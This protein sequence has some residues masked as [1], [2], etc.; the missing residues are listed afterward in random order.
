MLQFCKAYLRH[1]K[2]VATV[3]AVVVL[4]CAVCI[5]QVKV[6][7]SMTDYLPADSPSVQALNDMEE[8]FGAGTVNARLYAEGV[9][10]AQASQLA[11]DLAA[12][13][14]IDEVMW[15]GSVVDIRQP[16]ETIR[17]DT[18]ES[19]VTDDGYLY[20]LAISD[21]LGMQASEQARTTA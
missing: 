16:I 6:N 11:D 12:I 3:F 19:W 13:D 9:D 4:A 5:P 8:A 15:L 1:R 2:L 18:A 7:Y 10:I 14:G 20:Q 17:E 21:D